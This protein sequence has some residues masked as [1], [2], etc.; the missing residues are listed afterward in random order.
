[1]FLSLCA[2]ASFGAL[3]AWWRRYQTVSFQTYLALLEE[4][5]GE[6]LTE[7]LEALAASLLESV[8]MEELSRRVPEEFDVVCQGGGFR[9]CYSGG[10]AIALR[11]IQRRL[12]GKP[13]LKRFAGASAGA[14]L[15]LM[16]ATDQVPLG[17]KWALATARLYTMRPLTR[18]E[19]VW[20]H[21]LTKV[22]DKVPDDGVLHVAL[23]KLTWDS[24]ARNFG[25]QSTVVS[26]FSGS[27]DL[28]DAV[29]ATGALPFLM[30]GGLT[31]RFRGQLVT[32]G[33]VAE[34]LPLFT[35]G[36]RPQ[37]VCT[38]RGRLPERFDKMFGYTKEEVQELARLA[39]ADTIRYFGNGE[40]PKCME[41]LNEDEAHSAFRQTDV[42]EEFPL[43]RRFVKL[44]PGTD[45]EHWSRNSTPVDTPFTPALPLVSGQ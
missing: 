41:L 28:A 11:A 31:A 9:N 26:E 1:M 43:L 32:D 6:E 40:R 12:G 23:A 2:L 22:A 42:L 35:D 37:L 5:E 4:E 7:E 8:D 18:P 33:G 36:Q 10:V 34:N 24:V 21:I 30:T 17:L 3:V 38:F 13:E 15:N 16:W 44:R 20:R 14:Q 29:M 39:V 27:S 25:C 45:R 19:P